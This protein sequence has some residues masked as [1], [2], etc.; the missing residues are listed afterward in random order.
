M[1]LERL[2]ELAREIGFDAAGVAP[3]ALLSEEVKHLQQWVEE[4]MHAGMEYMA[5]NMEVRENPQ[6]LVDG[7]RSVIVTLTAYYQEADFPENAPVV[8]RYAWGKDYHLVVKERLY[9]LLERL[10]QEAG[11]IDGRCFVDSAPVLEHA[12]ARRAGLGWQGKNTLLIRKG[13]GSFCFIGVIVSTLSVEEY[14]RPFTGSFC[15]NC[16]RCVDA[17]PTRALKPFELD[18][19]KC[20]SYHTI[21]NKGDYPEEVK[22]AAGGRLFGCDICQEV[23]PWNQHLNLSVMPEFRPS[24]E[25]LHLTRQDWLEMDCSRFKQLFKHTPLERTGLS[26]ILKN[27]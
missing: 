26:R 16:Q 5:R 2:K 25:F 1:Q 24:P 18:A 19:R 17:C 11:E 22:Q 23:C 12:W 4:G 6:R 10:K 27:L 8:A 9:R 7:A 14:D 21:E 20:I 15:G 13:L 3:V